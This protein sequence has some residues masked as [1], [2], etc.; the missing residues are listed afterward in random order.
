MNPKCRVMLTVPEQMRGQRVRCAAC[1]EIFFV[2]P[3]AEPATKRK[4]LRK[5]S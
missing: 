3:P 2:P 1:G 5:A 4:R